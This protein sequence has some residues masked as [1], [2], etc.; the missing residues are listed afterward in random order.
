MTT[1]RLLRWK[2]AMVVVGLAIGCLAG[3]VVVR[4]LDIE[5][6]PQF[7]YHNLEGRD[8]KELDRAILGE[9]AFKSEAVRIAFIGDSFTY[10]L[11]VEPDQ[12]FVNKIGRRLRERL[13]PRFRTVNLGEPGADLVSECLTYIGAKDRVRPHVVVHV[14]TA[15]D[16]DFDNYK[17]LWEAKSAYEVRLWPSRIS[18]L[19]AFFEC[20]VRGW[21]G[22]RRTLD[23]M[24]GGG[25]EEERDRAW[26]LADCSIGSMK[27]LVEQDR[28]LYVLTRFPLL[29]DMDAS[30]QVEVRREMDGLTRRLGIPYVDLHDVLCHMDGERLHLPNDTHPT[31]ET[32]GLVAD[33]L[34]DFLEARI[35][36][37]LPEHSVLP[38]PRKA[39]PR[40]VREAKMQFLRSVLRCDPTCRTALVRLKWLVQPKRNR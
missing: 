13:S 25:T 39:P 30:C 6:E 40:R 2:I 34:A 12:T 18:K 9:D 38:P 4:V 24:R 21:I 11:G 31:V 22:E 29:I 16:L 33:A 36:R 35:L 19:F 10:G 14:I 3:E 27:N 1:K 23:Y 7:V 32:H 28:C 17:G 5:T 15:N 8:Q 26:R 20:T 37:T